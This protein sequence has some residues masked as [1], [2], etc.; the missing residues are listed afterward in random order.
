MLEFM[1]SLNLGVIFLGLVMSGVVG[2][3][4]YVVFIGLLNYVLRE[5]FNIWKFEDWKEEKFAI[6]TVSQIGALIIYLVGVPLLGLVIFGQKHYTLNLIQG[7]N[8]LVAA[9]APLLL[10]PLLRWLVDISRN[11]KIKKDT[12]DSVRLK[13]MQDQIDK[14]N[15]VVKEKEKEL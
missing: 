1:D 8:I 10:L 9:V 2:S 14:L 3:V 11:L 15:K 12:G 6:D 4:A 7:S 13:E 5:N